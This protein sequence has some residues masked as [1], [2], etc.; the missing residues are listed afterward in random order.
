MEILRTSQDL[1]GVLVMTNYQVINSIT[2][3]PVE[4]TSYLGSAGSH[5]Q[6]CGYHRSCMEYGKN[7]SVDCAAS[8]NTLLDG[9]NGSLTCD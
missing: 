5:I 6:L 7:P 8:M 9:S 4:D 2:S 1:I 3:K